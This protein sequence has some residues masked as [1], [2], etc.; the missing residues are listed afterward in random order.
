MNACCAAPLRRGDIGLDRRLVRGI[1]GGID[2]FAD[3]NATDYGGATLG[4]YALLNAHLDWRLDRNPA[5][6]LFIE[7]L[8]DR[9]YSLAYGYAAQDH[10]GWV[11]LSWSP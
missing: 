2:L 6:R 9:P 1:R 5:L 7:N 11:T 4:G 8:F 10:T 3:G